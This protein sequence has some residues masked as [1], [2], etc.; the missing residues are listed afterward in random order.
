[1]LWPMTK[2]YKQLEIIVATKDRPD[3]IARM[4]ESLSNSTKIPAKIFIVYYGS[5][6]ESQLLLSNPLLNLQFIQSQIASQIFQKKLGLKALSEDCKW[7][8]F[9]D[10]DV[11]IETNTL[12]KLF[13]LYLK[14]NTLSNYA[15]F[16]L[17]IK[18]RA[19]QNR[20][21]FVNFF[22]YL[23][24]LFSYKPGHITIGGHPQTYLDQKLDCEVQWL[25]GISLWQKKFIKSYFNL[26]DLTNYAA[27]EDVMFSYS[28]S[29]NSKLLF[30][31]NIFVL[32]QEPESFKPL[33]IDQ[34]ISACY[35][36]YFFVG[37][38]SQMSKFWLIVGQIV[39]SVNFIVES[40][41]Q[42]T[43]IYRIYLAHKLL[44][45]ITITKQNY[46]SGY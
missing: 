8:L 11:V 22:L 4:L 1:M 34:F 26:P 41:S 12:E 10:D 35:A 23:V 16:G 31:S 28:V 14:N 6:L 37:S 19:M 21:A 45:N 2:T 27:Y 17:A 18:N 38:Y 3:H 25:N 40:K 13:E 44:Y 20:N 39:R 32:D 33:T 9:L 36:R 7:V 15:G 5:I 43:Y 24:K 30:V 42:R 46:I 29:R